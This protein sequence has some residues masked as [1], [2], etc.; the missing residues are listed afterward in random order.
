MHLLIV[1]FYVGLALGLIFYWRFF[2]LPGI[3]PRAIAIAFLLKL[4][5]GYALAF[6][7]THHYENRRSGDAYRFFDD[8]VILHSSFNESPKAFARLMTGIGMETDPVAEVYY[9]R[10]TH[11]QLAFYTGYPNDNAT[12]IRANA[13]ALFLSGGYYHVHTVIW[14]FLALIGLTA[15]LKIFLRH[16]PDKKWLMFLSVYLLPT[17]LFWSSG[18]LKEPLLLLGLGLFL[19]GFFRWFDNEFTKKDIAPL[20]IGITFLLFTK[21][22]II[23]CMA[24]GL[25]FLVFLKL[26]KGKRFNLSII[27]PHVLT[28]LLIFLGP[29]LANGLKVN[30]IVSDRQTAFYNVAHTSNS[31][32][33]I[34]RSNFSINKPQPS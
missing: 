29:Y 18:V 1:L 28:V 17:V 22:Y 16:F 8:G 12:I 10:M 27:L 11:M 34:D 13:L 25:A 5:A 32:S 24:P 23:Q 15:L 3:K 2:E 26:N 9:H 19:L 20:L 31:G 33:I 14:C 7:Y 21:G 6:I 30:E 4:I